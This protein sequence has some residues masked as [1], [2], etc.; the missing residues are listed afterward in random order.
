MN[1]ETAE[2]AGIFWLCGLSVLCVPSIHCS[3]ITLR[4]AEEL[5]EQA[6]DALEDAPRCARILLGGPQNLGLREAGL[7]LA[8]AR[9][10]GPPARSGLDLRAALS[11]TRDS[12]H[13]LQFQTP[14]PGSSP[15]P[16]R[17]AD[18]SLSNNLR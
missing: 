15:N 4:L 9:S 7:D 3:D 14:Y 12:G 8:R 10:S 11:G 1:A 13:P 6:A 18:L 16:H 5:A 2:F 17:P